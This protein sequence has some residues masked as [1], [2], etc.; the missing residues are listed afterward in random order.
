[1]TEIENEENESYFFNYEKWPHKLITRLKVVYSNLEKLYILPKK[2]LPPI[3]KVTRKYFNDTFPIINILKNYFNYLDESS[4]IYLHYALITINYCTIEY[5]IN[6]CDIMNSLIKHFNYFLILESNNQ[7][8]KRTYKNTY[9]EHYL[10]KRGDLE[11]IF[12][13]DEAFFSYRKL[14]IDDNM[15]FSYIPIKCVYVEKKEEDCIYREKCPFAHVDKE[16]YYH[17]LIYKKILCK[18]KT[19]EKCSNKNC[20]FYH[21]NSEKMESDL[22]FDSEVIKNMIKE[23][24]DIIKNS[25]NE[26]KFYIE[27]L[28]NKESI[29]SEFNPL[30]YKTHK[31]PLNLLC[32]LPV[33][34]CLNYH[35]DKNDR[36]RPYQNYKAEFCENVMNKGKP[37]PNAICP[38]RD[39]CQKCHNKYEYMYHLD[40]FRKKLCPFTKKNKNCQNRLVCPF[41]HD[42]DKEE[43]LFSI[44]SLNK[45][46]VNCNSEMIKNYYLKSMNHYFEE[47]KKY[48]QELKN[49][50]NLHKCPEC[51]KNNMLFDKSYNQLNDFFYCDKCINDIKSNEEYIT[52]KIND[53]IK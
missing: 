44:D 6:I 19:T 16:I 42:D 11:H 49:K 4:L 53:D 32:K 9:F 35:D 12:N 50:W 13:P 46:M 15:Y 18:N 38:Y 20:H 40:I 27:E 7:I 51:H 25:E 41:F 8:K 10:I 39:E 14:D 43:S 28:R 52:I 29:P 45:T 17:P 48:Y 23:I 26:Q 36:R 21:E 5:F 30:T 33:N 24:K 2:R 37:I 3:K 47:G 34:Q 22:D 31:C 1:M